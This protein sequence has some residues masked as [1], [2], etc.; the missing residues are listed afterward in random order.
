MKRTE[1]DVSSQPSK[2]DW[3]AGMVIQI[4]S[5]SFNPGFW[6]GTGRQL[7]PAAQAGTKSCQLCQ[8]RRIEK[9]HMVASR[10]ARRARGPT[11][12]MRG[13]HRVDESAIAAAITVHHG[14]PRR[15]YID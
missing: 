14:I 5:G 10:A 15:V 9:R 11:I 13:G 7:R 2:C 1:S 4:A 8:L 12:Y 6:L 3:L